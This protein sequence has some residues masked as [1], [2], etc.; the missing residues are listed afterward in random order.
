[1]VFDEKVLGLGCELSWSVGEKIRIRQ[2]F[3]IARTGEPAAAVTHVHAGVAGARPG[4]NALAL[5]GSATVQR[6][7]G[8]SREAS[9]SALLG[10][11]SA[12]LGAD[13]QQG[14][15]ASARQES[16]SVK[17][18]HVA[19]AKPAASVHVHQEPVSAKRALDLLVVAR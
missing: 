5:R 18:P 9:A 1:L 8:A 12:A 2:W 15:N 16:A 11:V 10:S 3:V 14:G 19:D 13:A 6:T 4:E 17:G 7:A